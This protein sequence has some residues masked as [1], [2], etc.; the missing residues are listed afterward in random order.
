M[1]LKS[2]RL[3]LTHILSRKEAIF[4]WFVLLGFV[5]WNFISNIILDVKGIN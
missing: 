4:T 3:Q 1:L 2:I 5:T